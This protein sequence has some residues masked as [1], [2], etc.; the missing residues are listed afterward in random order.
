VT[1]TN[2]IAIAWMQFAGYHSDTAT[3]TR[4]LAEHRV[5]GQAAD[6][7]WQ[8][9]VRLRQSG[10]GCGCADCVNRRSMSISR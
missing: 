9:G 4:L 6:D 5:S 1:G 7:A 3:F 8:Q 2:A 10:A